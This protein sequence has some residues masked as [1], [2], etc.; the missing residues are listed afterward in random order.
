MN[1]GLHFSLDNLP[2]RYRVQAEQQLAPRKSELVVPSVCTEA[3]EGL[4][5]PKKRIAAP[6]KTRKCA[7][8]MNKTESMF[9]QRILFG[10]GMYEALKFKVAEKCVYTPDFCVW[11]E[12]GKLTCY[13]VKGSYPL[14]SEG[15]ART[16]FLACREKYTHV[17]FRWF[18]LK[19]NGYF[20]EKLV[21]G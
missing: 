14:P 6:V 1:T 9:N 17:A 8:G 13:E 21:N 2:A 12:H 19:K 10:E 5:E 18:K 4:P 7:G 15:R 3:V 16:A 20:E 11:D